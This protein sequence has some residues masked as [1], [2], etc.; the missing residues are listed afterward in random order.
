MLRRKDRK[1]G[2]STLEYVIMFTGVITILMVFLRSGGPFRTS[3][4]KTF[5][6]AINGMEKMANRLGNSRP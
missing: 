2:Q 4:E 5:N 6:A 3:T 1:R